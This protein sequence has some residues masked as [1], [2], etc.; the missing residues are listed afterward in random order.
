MQCA[1]CNKG[2]GKEQRHGDC[3]N[4]HCRWPLFRCRPHDPDGSAVTYRLP[5]D[6]HP[7]VPLAFVKVADEPRPDITILMGPSTLLPVEF[8]TVSVCTI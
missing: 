7:E 1:R 4:Q 6:A 3:S 8:V 5:D 2:R